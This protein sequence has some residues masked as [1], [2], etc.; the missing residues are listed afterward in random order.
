MQDYTTATVAAGSTVV[1]PAWDGTSGGILAFDWVLPGG[2]ELTTAVRA[3][4][5]GDYPH[6]LVAYPGLPA[7]SAPTTTTTD[8]DAAE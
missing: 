6:W 1:A 5:K 7:E 4:E 8:P 2:Q 3:D